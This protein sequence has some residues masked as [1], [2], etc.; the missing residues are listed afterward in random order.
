VNLN[1]AI[2]RNYTQKRIFLTHVT[3]LAL[4][5][6]T[7]SYSA[8]VNIRFRLQQVIF[9]GVV[10]FRRVRTV[11]K[12]ALLFLSCPSVRLQHLL[13]LLPLDAFMWHLI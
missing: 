5:S 9:S 12:K 13:P 4:L 10:L 3:T 1:V 2:L 8:P 11:A 6:I 7:S